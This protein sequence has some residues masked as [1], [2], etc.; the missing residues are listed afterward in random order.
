M[1]HE[2]LKAYISNII[3]DNQMIEKH[4]DEKTNLQNVLNNMY[5]IENALKKTNN[6]L[7][8]RISQTQLKKIIL[9]IL[10][11]DDQDE[12]SHTQ[13][14]KSKKKLQ[15]K[16]KHVY[17]SDSSQTSNEE[18]D[19]AKKILK[20]INMGI[21][22]G[23]NIEHEGN[24]DKIE[25]HGYDQ[26][27]NEN[28]ESN[29]IKTNLIKIKGEENSSTNSSLSN[30]K[31]CI[32]NN[33]INL[34]TYK[35]INNIKKD[36]YYSIVY[37][38]KYR[39][40]NFNTIIN[41]NGVN[42]SGKTSL[43]Y[44]IAGE[45]DSHF[46]YIKLPEYVR[47]LSNDNKNNKLRILFEQI[48]KEY[49]KCILCI[50]D[51]DILFNSKD[52][53]IDIYIFTYLLSLFDN[54][55]VVI[56]LLSINKP[57]DTI[58]Y[59]KI[60]KFI[61]MPIPTYED[62]IEILQNLSQN[63]EINFDV[64]YTAS[65][66]YGFNRAQIYDILN[67]SKNLY[68]YNHVLY[69]KTTPNFMNNKKD[70]PSINISGN[71][72][73]NY[74]PSLK[75]EPDDTTHY[76]GEEKE[77][78]FVEE[79]SLNCVSNE[80][81]ND[82]NTNSVKELNNGEEAEKVTNLTKRKERNNNDYVDIYIKEKKQKKIIP[83]NINNDIIYESIKNIKKKITTQNICEV[84]NINLDNIGSLKNIKKI[85]ETKF[86]LP[87]K[88]SNIYKHLGIN[89]SMGILLYGPPGCGKTMLAKAISNEMK[90]NFIAIKG[91]E[92]LN[93]YVGE[94]EKKVREIFSYASTYKPCLIFF[95]EIDSICINRDNN[96]TAAASDRVVNQLLT[97]MD[98]LSQREGIYIIATTNRP[99]IIDK[100]LLR[101]GRFD[102]LI[103]VSLP[104]YQGRIDIL[105]KLSKNMPLDK[106][107][108]FKQISILTKGYSGADLHGVL[109][110]SAFIALQE[111]RDKID[112]F[113]YKSNGPT[114]LIPPNT[115]QSCNNNEHTQKEKQNYFTTTSENTLNPVLN[116][117]YYDTYILNENYDQPND[118]K[119]DYANP[120][121]LEH[122]SSENGQTINNEMNNPCITDQ[123]I[124][125][126]VQNKMM[127]I[128]E[129][130]KTLGEIKMD[131]RQKEEENNNKD[132]FLY[133]IEDLKNENLQEKDKN[134]LIYEF[135]QKNKN[136][137]A[138][139]QKHILL[140]INI[141]PRSVT[142]K[143]MK[144]YKE[145]SKKFK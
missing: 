99:D 90:A 116:K 111:C 86:I 112:R 70:T 97:E 58:L 67:E 5:L 35:G 78:N 92:I 91:P 104:K 46:F 12:P 127:T 44:A 137:L 27:N 32:D 94:S 123:N 68:I 145:I 57:Y 130:N 2:K 25:K 135:I 28:V 80:I 17:T 56:I 15:N 38:Y 30:V 61:S 39:N 119:M 65:I 128:E 76:E 52:D 72:D 93:K 59:S 13:I 73:D 107:I 62:R 48:K 79:N 10:K 18:N 37:P 82:G 83:I 89:K 24:S 143:Q 71:E 136:I 115:E 6:K 55:N 132:N 129:E 138:I 106:D 108:N 139:K 1:L 118:N 54:T 75:M 60:Q 40:D 140:A 120:K 96:K 126:A 4:H 134:N 100:A 34:N 42:G 103:Y 64:L 3:T 16:S 98:G 142:K 14:D 133:K 124:Y 131:E 81:E 110:E 113:N 105:K 50:D 109:R 45:C 36:I 43:A 125:D 85:L 9:C 87:V 51:M 21:D 11:N 101:T 31:V 53:T 77:P 26:I 114:P 41:I 23:T 95:D 144:Y 33:T 121:S 122:Y 141:V 63:L 29:K 49:N 47:Y 88:Y 20:K 102:Q 8:R 69:D 74:D 84:P 117:N 7:F 19:K 66:T 22:I